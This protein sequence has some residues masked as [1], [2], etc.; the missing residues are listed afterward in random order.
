MSDTIASIEVIEKEESPFTDHTFL[1]YVVKSKSN[2]S[3]SHI[4]VGEKIWEISYAM[5]T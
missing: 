4:S 5:F 1:H 2:Q 3:N